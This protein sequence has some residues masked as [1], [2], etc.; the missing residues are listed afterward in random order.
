MRRVSEKT[1]VKQI[2]RALNDLP[3]CYARK[4]LASA[5]NV[6][7]ADITGCHKGRRFE[8]EVKTPDKDLQKLQRHIQA[9]W[10]AAGAIAVRVRSKEEALEA[11]EG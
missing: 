8:F 11:L 6:G 3:G 5:G 4:R 1:I 7:E 10:R 9:K 2:L